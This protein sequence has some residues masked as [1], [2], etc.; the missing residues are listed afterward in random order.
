MAT[1][2]MAS[3]EEVKQW[4]AEGSAVI[5]D[6]RE[7]GEYAQA[8]IPGSTLV[9]LSSFDPAAI[10]PVGPDQHLVIHCA[11]GMRC[12]PAS[13]MVKASGFPGDI[14]RLAGGIMAWYRAGGEI[15]QG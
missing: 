14:N 1:V 13:M 7:R 15:E 5:V 12:E 3:P 8:R 10:P 2:R 9:P 6:V 4:V 11:S